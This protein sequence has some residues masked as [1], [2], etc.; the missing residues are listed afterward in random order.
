MN[1]HSELGRLT[2]YISI[3]PPE[4]SEQ[5]SVVRSFDV[6]GESNGFLTKATEDS[7]KAVGQIRILQKMSVEGLSLEFF[8]GIEDNTDFVRFLWVVNAVMGYIPNATIGEV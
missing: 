8:A 4:E 5:V 1:C 7:V 2:V 6:T 3:A